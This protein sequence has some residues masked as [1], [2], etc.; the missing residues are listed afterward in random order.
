[1]KFNQANGAE[2]P[3]IGFGTFELEPADAR[4]MVNH[5]LHVGYR[6]VDTAQMY[7]NEEAVGQGIQDS[8]VDR[9]SVFLTTKVRTRH[10][11]D[12]DLQQS[13]QG[14]LKKLAT[15][16]VDLLLLHWPNPDVELEET[17]NALMDV[18]R[19]GLTRHIGISNF[20][21]VLTEQ[22]LAVCGQHA[23][24]T[25][26]VEY[27]VFLTQRSVKDEVTGAGMALTAYCPVARGKVMGNGTL[28][29]IGDKYGKNEAQVALRWLL[30]QDVIAIPKTTNE[31]HAESNL[32]IL[33]FSLDK[34]DMQVI[35][36]KLQGDDRQIDPGFAPEWDR[37]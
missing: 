23:L 29:S 15:D 32:D 36:D 4:R 21:N 28:K 2:I 22:A 37:P 1:M 27:H 5:A 6:H 35:D 25:N 12:G 33:D 34:E 3:S 14:S 31:Q 9:S 16:Y 13:V 18:K 10:F 11:H 26:Q 30:E 20:P 19:Q 8:G 17:L 7:E 24:V